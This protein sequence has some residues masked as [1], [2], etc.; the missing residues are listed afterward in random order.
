LILGLCSQTLEG[1][2][3]LEVKVI[4]RQDSR[5]GYSYVVPGQTTSS[6]NT[7]VNCFD[8]SL[9]NMTNVNCGGTTTGTATHIPPRQIAYEVTGST[10]SLELPDG[11]IAVVNCVSKYSP[12]GDYINQR[13]C[14]VPLVNKIEVEFNGKNAKLRWPVSID[15]KKF[16][17]ETYRILSVIDRP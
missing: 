17:S 4:D 3:K 8:T 6:S 12:K 7:N 2:Q 10:L 1:Q 15:G 9:G 5:T 16:D 14:R 13:S 11:R